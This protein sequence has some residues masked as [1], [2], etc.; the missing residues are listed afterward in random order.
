MKEA[1][2]MTLATTQSDFRNHMKHYLDMVNDSS[3]VVYIARSK[4]RAAAVIDQ[5]KLD[6]LE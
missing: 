3:E 5:N 4:Q 6:W 1:I 2:K